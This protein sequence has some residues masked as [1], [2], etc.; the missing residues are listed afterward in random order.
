V[1]LIS[2][3]TPTILRT[4]LGAFLPSF[5]GFCFSL[6][7]RGVCLGAY[8]LGFCCD[9]VTRSKSKELLFMLKGVLSLPTFFGSILVFY[10]RKGFAGLTDL[11]IFEIPSRESR[12]TRRDLLLVLGSCRDLTVVGIGSSID[13]PTGSALGGLRGYSCPPS[14]TSDLC[15]KRVYCSGTIPICWYSLSSS[16][17]FSFSSSKPCNLSLFSWSSR[18]RRLIVCL[19]SSAFC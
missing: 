10:P 7:V 4:V 15:T 18:L 17:S 12:I 13:L 2:S 9:L 16:L 8:S 1:K 3:S 11:V 19:F 6:E 14:S 5:S